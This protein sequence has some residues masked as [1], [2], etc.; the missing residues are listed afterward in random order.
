MLKNDVNH[1]ANDRNYAYAG[2]ET[3]GDRIRA[4]RQA[5]GMTL[6]E[7]AAIVGVGSAAI[8]QWE[9]GRHGRH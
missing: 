9:R 2:M 4:I 5:R 6:D 8:S 7:V 1:A 3:M